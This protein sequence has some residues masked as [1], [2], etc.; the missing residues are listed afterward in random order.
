M[1][2]KELNKEKLS[3]EELNDVS[4]GSL[5]DVVFEPMLRDEVAWDEQG[6][7]IE[8]KWSNDGYIE[9]YRYKCP[10]CPG[11]LHSGSW[12]ALYCDVC[13]EAFANGH[14]SYRVITKKIKK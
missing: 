11:F 2:N 14:D 10:H 3:E 8:W 4:G 5:L 9:Y 1:E 12:I 13:D 6:R 7:A